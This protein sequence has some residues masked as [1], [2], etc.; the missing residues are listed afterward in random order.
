VPTFTTPTFT[1]PAFTR[2]TFTMPAAPGI[3][4]TAFDLSKLTLPSFDVRKGDLSGVDVARFGDVAR[5][6]AYAGVGLVALTL[7][8]VAERRRVIQTEISTRARRLAD[9]IA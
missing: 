8:K 2:P 5:D 4:L 9:A 1:M 3:D 7:E 6:A